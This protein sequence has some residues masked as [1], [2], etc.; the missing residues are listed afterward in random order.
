MQ[1]NDCNLRLVATVM[2]LALTSCTG[3]GD[4]TNASTVE[5]STG[6]AQGTKSA[7]HTTTDH[8][9][10]SGGADASGGARD[11]GGA[12]ATGGR[13]TGGTS[14]AMGG[15]TAKG[16]S[17]S[18]SST[19][20]QS[21]GA[22]SRSGSSAEGGTKPSSTEGSQGGAS[23]GGS[24]TAKGGASADGGATAKG[25]A[26]ATS[27]TATGATFHVF[28]LLGQSNMAGYPKAQQ[29]DKV[30]DP[31]VK[32]L[33]FDDCSATG[34][35]SDKWDTAA[36]PLHEC[37]NGALGPGDYFA[38]TLLPRIPSQDT[39]GL[40]PCAI[41]GEKIETFMK[42]GGSKYNWIIQRAKAAKDAGGVIEGMIFHQGESNSGDSSWPGKVNTFVSDLRK[43]LG[44]EN[45]PFIAGEL[46]RD[47]A[48]A[49]HNKLVNQLPTLISKSYVVTAEGLIVDPADT[50]WNMH[51]DHDSQVTLGKRYGEKMISALGW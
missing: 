36:P 37:W 34:R 49:G 42:S 24:A 40:V 15:S 7:A 46:P 6:G 16:G 45:A 1:T 43:D 48:A 11:E 4:A 32:V 35:Q 19:K 41:S 20:P 33:G 31:R 5:G 27:A 21:G 10:S 8:A 29:A 2:A 51:F 17:S 26:S 12:T 13:S 39:I 30:E 9:S 18:L 44:I 38:K 47:G 22:S 3:S 50:Q 28:L 14:R 25:G 23:V